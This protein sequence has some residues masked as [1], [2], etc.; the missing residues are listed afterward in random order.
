M[1]AL[2]DTQKTPV[3]QGGPPA[4]DAQA[5]SGTAAATASTAAA[6]P[7]A[8]AGLDNVS[9]SYQGAAETVHG[10]SLAIQPGECVVLCGMS[11][12][13]KTSIVRLVNGLAGGFYPGSHTGTVTLMR[14]DAA[15]YA[16]WE[17]ARHVG[18]VFQEP[19]AQFFSSQL[20]G[21]IAF[22]VE[23]LGLPHAQVVEAVDRVIS[24]FS[25]DHLRERRIDT[26]SSGE[27]QKVAIA[28]ACVNNPDL[29]CMDEPSSNLDEHS[30]RYL[31]QTLAQIKQQGLGMLIAEHRIAYLMDVADRFCIID[32]GC[33]VAELTPDE[34]RAWP[35]AQRV[36]Y[37]LRSPVFL[38]R[39]V[40]PEPEVGTCPVPETG[41]APEPGLTPESG[42]T[43]ESQADNSARAPVLQV[44]DVCVPYGKHPVV[45]HA[46]FTVDAGM[47]VALV[48]RN[49]CGKTTF[50]RALAGLSKHSQGD[51]L[52]RGKACSRAQRR[53][54]VWFSPNDV[55]SEFFTTSVAE[56]V[57]LLMDPTE[58]NKAWAREVL[59]RLG[60]WEL[61]DHYPAT[62]SGGQQQR[63]SIAC[64]LVQRRPILVLDEPTSGLDACTMGQ[65]SDAL[66]LAAGN[67]Q[68]ILVTTHD[69]EF[70]ARACTHI[71]KMD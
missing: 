54:L 49:G 28:S 53:R 10:V 34:M 14:K 33:L 44:R 3:P 71:H 8:L 51:F 6:G 64:G 59:G 17:R 13:G 50:C 22:T 67:G 2:F 38:D 43:P 56:E 30:T 41:P 1:S 66:E 60:L 45:Q 24:H 5:A 19:A 48:G 46:S 4:E 20:A 26:L 21:E 68:A 40:L 7:G 32:K 61:K 15:S 63:L 55:R 39:P 18:S 31:G 9:F 58:E 69:N 62:L 42:P 29:L 70:L 37:G 52:I 12:S 35:E 23:N 11:G 16:V 36:R 27:K 25:L 65:L 57:M 47:V